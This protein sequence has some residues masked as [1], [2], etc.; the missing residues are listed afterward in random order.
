VRS[1][2][3]P[4]TRRSLTP[5][6]FPPSARVLSLGYSLVAAVTVPLG[7]YNLDDSI[8]VQKLSFGLLGVIV[9]LW[10]LSFGATGLHA[11]VPV[12]GRDASGLIGTLLFNYMFV[13]TVPSWLNEKRPGVS[14]RRSV[15]GAVGLGSFIFASV[16]LLGAAA[17]GGAPDG[18]T[19]SRDLL[20]LLL[21]RGG[22]A[23]RAAAYAFPPVALMSGIPVLSICV[24]YNLVEQRVASPATASLLAVLLPWAC[25]LL[26]SRGGALGAA[27]DWASLFAAVPLNLVLPAWLYLE[28]TGEGHSAGSRGAGGELQAS[29]LGGD[30]GGWGASAAS[31]PVPA[32]ARVHAWQLLRADAD[33][34]AEAEGEEAWY[35]EAEEGDGGPGAAHSVPTLAWLP[36]AAGWRGALADLRHGEWLDTEVGRKRAAARLVVATGVALNTA[37]FAV[38]IADLAAHR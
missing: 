21:R 19:A 32:A 37:A 4:L 31:P 26:L 35:F 7:Y 22:R 12:V 38:K 11:H 27:M 33:A 20:T 28:A 10:L 8:W 9:F 15:V 18:F 24:R 2:Y 36:A 29:L 5:P 34:G 14:V 23:A 17:Y 13:A 25:A 3:A 1:L 16:G 30:Q 6:P